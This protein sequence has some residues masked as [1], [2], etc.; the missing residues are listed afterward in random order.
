MY[1]LN[2]LSSRISAFRA[3]SETDSLPA[4]EEQRNSDFLS[5]V[6]NF[7]FVRAQGHSLI[8]WV[9]KHEWYLQSLKKTSIF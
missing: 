7:H 4:I 5:Q 6:T 1:W 2:I 9:T 3:D 8:K